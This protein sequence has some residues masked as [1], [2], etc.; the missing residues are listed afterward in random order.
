VTRALLRRCALLGALTVALTACGADEPAGTSASQT[1][2]TS[3]APSESAAAPASGEPFGPGCSALPP[4]G[5]GSIAGM[6]DDPVGRA[7]SNNAALST[8]VQALMAA[9]LGDSLNGQEAITVLAPANAAFEAIPPADLQALMADTARLTAVLTH[10]VIS[11]RLA[12]EE[13]AGTH[14]TL[15]NDQV[16]VDGGREMFTVSGEGTVTGTVATVVCADIQTANA[17]VYVIDQVLAPAS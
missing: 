4:D 1:A 12:P 5:E 17:T 14:T 11:G 13:L 9:D 10:H 15:N 7:A 3:A 16:T 8:L 2:T 6:A